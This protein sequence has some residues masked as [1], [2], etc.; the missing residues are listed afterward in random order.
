LSVGVVTTEDGCTAG[1]LRMVSITT[2]IICA[3]KVRSA[4]RAG[5]PIGAVGGGTAVRSCQ[6]VPSTCDTPT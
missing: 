5:A 4:Y 1:A 6:V 3:I 2:L